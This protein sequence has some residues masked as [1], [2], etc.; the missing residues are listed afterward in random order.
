MACAQETSALLR[1][2]IVRSQSGFFSVQTEAGLFECHLR[3][4]LKRG[5]RSGDL[6]AIGDWVWVRPLDERRGVIEAVEPRQRK[7]ARMA[8]TPRGEYEQIIIANPDQA[9]FVFA[10]EQPKPRFGMLDR[11][12]VI[13]E[14]ENIPAIIVANKVDLVGIEQAHA[15]FGHYEPIGY[16]VL[17]TSAK[18]G[19]GLAE[20]RQCLKGKVSV[21]TGPSGSGKTSLLNAIQ[22][23]LG[24]EVR[25][26]SRAT[27]KGTHTTVVSQMF[28]LQEGGYIADTP[29]LKSLALW[30][31]TP[32]ELDGYFPELRPLVS[33][34]QF[35]DCTHIHEPKCAVLQ[36][37]AEG[38]V[39]P[40]RYESYVR[41]RLGEELA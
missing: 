4:K 16:P 14:K 23:G 36:A 35:S 29:G 25:E 10:C 27:G 39:H 38:K 1:G 20:L 37:V 18:S 41:M 26:V 33:A 13:A 9:V 32:D 21:L 12:L 34:C 30:D 3:G 19:Y 31:V 17:Y 8:P 6:A 40:A 24:L 15:L 5:E 11:F 7:I 22:P 28:P 2:L